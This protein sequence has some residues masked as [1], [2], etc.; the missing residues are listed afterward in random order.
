MAQAILRRGSGG[1]GSDRQ[2][3]DCF[4]TGS[5]GTSKTM[6]AGRSPH[7]PA[8]AGLAGGG[9]RDIQNLRYLRTSAA[10]PSPSV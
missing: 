8:W 4:L 10:R 7:H 5:A 1:G 3:T 9:Y 6:I 2:C